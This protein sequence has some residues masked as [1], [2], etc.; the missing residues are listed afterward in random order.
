MHDTSADSPDSSK[1]CLQ[2][3]KVPQIDCPLSGE[4][5]VPRM[6]ASFNTEYV[7]PCSVIKV[8]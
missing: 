2:P 7:F 1:P 5:E 3:F 8:G 6:E 4:R